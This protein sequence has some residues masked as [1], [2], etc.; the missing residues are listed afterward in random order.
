G[1]YLEATD[2]T[3]EAT[4]IRDTS[5]QPADGLLGRGISV[6]ADGAGNPASLVLRD[7]TILRSV[8]AGVSVFDASA[9][10]ERVSVVATAARPDGLF[11]DGIF[12][13]GTAGDGFHLVSS[14]VDKSARASMSAFGGAASLAGSMLTCSAF[15][16]DIEPLGDAQPAVE[17]AGGNL[18]GCDSMTSC[19]AQGANLGPV[20]R[21]PPPPTR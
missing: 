7:S 3:V 19:H 16:I 13:H 8:E 2:G 1:L 11:G 18:C 14:H 12:V 20:D 6:Q 15:D 5:A 4:T 21:M 10:L 17:D 9:T